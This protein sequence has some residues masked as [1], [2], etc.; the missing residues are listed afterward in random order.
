MSAL[1]DTDETDGSVSVRL[2]TILPTGLDGGA[3]GTGSGTI[4][5]TDAGAQPAVDVD[6][7]S[8]SV[9]EGATVSYRV[10]LHT[11]PGGT[12][13]VTP[14]SGDSTRLTVPGALSFNSGTWSNWQTV[15]LT[16]LADSDLTDNDV[17]VTHTVSGYGSVT[18]APSVTVSIID[19]GAGVTVNPTA[20][21]VNEGANGSYSVRLNSRPSAS[22]TITPTSGDTVTATVGNAVTFAPAEWSSQKSIQVSGVNGGQARISHSV[23]STDTAY[24]AVTPSPVD[25]TVT[26]TARVRVSALTVIAVEHGAAGTYDVWLNTDPGAA[27]TVTPQTTSS[28]IGLSAALSF[29]SSNFRVP[30]RV[31]VTANTDT[32]TTSESATITH[33][34]SGYSG[35]NQGPEVAVTVQDAGSRILVSPT[36]LTV[37]E[38]ASTSYTLTTTT[39]P[40]SNVTLTPTGLGGRVTVSPS[41]ATFGP[42]RSLTQQVTVQGVAVGS[43]TLNHRIAASNPNSSFWRVTVPPVSVRVTPADAVIVSPINLAASEGGTATYYVELA[44]DPGGAVTVTPASSDTGAATVSGALSFNSSNW[45]AP[46]SVT[47]TAVQDG[48]GNH[49][50]VTISHQVSG[51]TGVSS[52]PSVTLFVGDDEFRPTASVQAGTGGNRTEGQAVTFDFSAPDIT[53]DVTLHYNVSA[54]GGYVASGDLG[55]KT[56]T[57][58]AGG[59][60]PGAAS[61]SVATLADS[62][63]EPAGTVT[64]TLTNHADYTVS[65]TAGSATRTVDDNDRGSATLAAPAGNIAEDGGSKTLTLTLN[66]ALVAGRAWRSSWPSAARR[67]SAPTSPWL[68]PAPRRPA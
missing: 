40:T 13:T 65:A 37:K 23:S 58:P 45:D 44:S 48:D 59:A 19:G 52:A 20:L 4:Q 28:A 17:T 3:G 50:N 10:K 66:R 30:Q 11:N 9:N 16:S 12:V 49:E 36:S 60:T 43:V 54:T 15:T 32:N 61:I 34:V 35:V 64:V 46:R 39:E 26:G 5:L 57:V 22:V 31:T 62:I 14:Q 25:V 24:A 53:S 8:L 63:D 47:V 27:V 6:M 21:S 55:A 56:L 7:D 42:G 1:A 68:H 2:G 18:T 41:P 51:Y 29:N 33:T 38:G 67:A